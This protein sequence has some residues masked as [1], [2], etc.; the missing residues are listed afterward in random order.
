MEYHLV[1]NLKEN[2]Y[3]D[4][5]LLNLKENGNLFF[6]S[7]FLCTESFFICNNLTLYYIYRGPNK[8]T[9]FWLLITASDFKIQNFT[10]NHSKK[11]VLNFVFDVFFGVFRETYCIKGCD[12]NVSQ[13][14]ILRK[15][16]AT[17]W[18]R[19]SQISSGPNVHQICTP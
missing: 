14:L 5:I 1:Q 12:K 2:C 19:W 10:L 11:G 8:R 18:S 17:F 6:V 7:V 16:M 4:H 13:F 3:H 9:R 15:K